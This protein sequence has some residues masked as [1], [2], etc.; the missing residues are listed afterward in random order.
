LSDIVQRPTP[1]NPSEFACVDFVNSSFADHLVG[2]EPVDRLTE[3]DWQQWFLH[4]YDLRPKVADSPPLE[5]LIALR[6][7]LRTL[8]EKWSRRGDLNARD[9]RLLDDRLQRTPMRRRVALTALGVEL[10]DEP[11]QKDWNWVIA[12]VTTS[13]LHLV[14][15]GDHQRLKTCGNPNCTWMFYDSTSNRSKQFCS[16]TPCGVLMRVRRFRDGA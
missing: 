7:D 14:R 9:V 10:R 3:R 6:R 4:R 8:L 15:T 12:S 16:T 13:A 11:L 5:E 1:T 2:G